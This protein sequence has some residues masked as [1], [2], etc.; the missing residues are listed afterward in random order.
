MKKFLEYLKIYFQF[1]FDEYI[2]EDMSVYNMFGK[3]FLYPAYYFSMIYMYVFSIVFFPFFLI[4]L[5][6][7]LN[8]DKFEEMFQKIFK[9]MLDGTH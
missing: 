6:M 9:P 4:A 2:Y 7:E 8:K 1:I 3:I 5:Y